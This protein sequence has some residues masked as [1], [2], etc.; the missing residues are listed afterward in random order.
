MPLSGNTSTLVGSTSGAITGINSLRTPKNNLATLT[1]STILDTNTIPTNI[2][3]VVTGGP[4]EITFE[5]ATSGCGGSV[6]FDTIGDL[7]VSSCRIGGG[8]TAVLAEPTCADVNRIVTQ[9]AGQRTEGS[10]TCTVRADKSVEEACRDAQTAQ[11]VEEC[12]ITGGDG[13][14]WTGNAFITDVGEG[15]IS[16]GEYIFSVTIQPETTWTFVAGTAMTIYATLYTAWKA[17]TLQTWTATAPSGG[18]Y[19]VWAG[20]GFLSAIGG[21][22]ISCKGVQRFDVTI[23]PTTI[24]D[25][26]PAV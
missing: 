24:F 12:V 2:P 6:A 25:F 14:T 16:N 17:A 3:G 5:Q 11:T 1:A 9:I 15:E 10:V 7:L 20:G 19:G 23:T 4:F 13:S 18:T 26:T 22:D 21:I 8:S